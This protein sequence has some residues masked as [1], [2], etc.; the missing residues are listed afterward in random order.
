MEKSTRQ[1][2]KINIGAGPGFAASNQGGGHSAGA[3]KP[4]SRVKAGN[5][6]RH[7]GGNYGIMKMSSERCV[8]EIKNA[9]KT[10]ASI[11]AKQ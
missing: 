8:E 11:E 5:S 6:K 4:G 9:F 10:S 3:A 2:S 7:S 1:K